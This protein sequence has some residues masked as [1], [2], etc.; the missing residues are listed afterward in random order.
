M[1]FVDGRVRVYVL[2]VA[3]LPSLALGW[4]CGRSTLGLRS[5]SWDYYRGVGYMF[6]LLVGSGITV[7]SLG[8][9][10]G[11]LDQHWKF[12]KRHLVYGPF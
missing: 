12:W 9:S 2:E 10:S 11:L 1:K 8:Q 7:E 6:G 5:G 4:S 3:L